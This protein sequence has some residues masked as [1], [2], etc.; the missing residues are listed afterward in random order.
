MSVISEMIKK[1]EKEYEDR[2]EE[3]ERE[4]AENEKRY[5]DLRNRIDFYRGW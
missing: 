2:K 4:A 3:N 5:E 1:L